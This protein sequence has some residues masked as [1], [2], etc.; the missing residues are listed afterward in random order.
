MQSIVCTPINIKNDYLKLPQKNNVAFS[1]RQFVL[2][3]SDEFIKTKTALSISKRLKNKIKTIRYNTYFSIYNRLKEKLNISDKEPLSI[4]ENTLS[5][6]S[7]KFRKDINNSEAKT[8]CTALPESA[9][10]IM[11]DINSSKLNYDIMH[12]PVIF[13]NQRYEPS[14]YTDNYEDIKTGTNKRADMNEIDTEIMSI[15]DGLILELPTGEMKVKKVK[16]KKLDEP[17]EIQSNISEKYSNSVVWDNNKI[18]RDL[19]QNFFDGHGQ[20]LDGVKIIIEPQKK[21]LN[22]KN[23]KVRIE[24]KSTYNYR[25]AVLLGES[26][27]HDNNKAAGNYGEGLKMVALKLLT[28]SETPEVKIG[29]GNWQVSC[30]LKKDERLDS[31][32]MNYKINPVEEYDGNFVEFE[33]S[34]NG[35]LMAIKSSV[36]RFYHSSNP[37]FKNPDFENDLFGIKLLN[38]CETGGLYISGQQFEYNDKFD[39]FNGIFFVKEKIPADVYN[40]TRDRSSIDEVTLS[41]IAN[42]ISKQTSDDECKQVIKCLDPCDNN[43]SDEMSVIHGEFLDHLA[44]KIKYRYAGAIKFPD[45]YV[46]RVLLCPEDFYCEIEK[47]GYKIYPCDYEELGMQSVANIK[48]KSEQ[49]IPLQPTE[50]EQIKIK[51]LKRA[52]N[53]LSELTKE[54]FDIDELDAKIYIFDRKGKAENS[55]RDYDNTNAEA[56][57]KDN[58]CLGFWID[59]TYLDKAAFGNVLETALHELSHKAGGDNSEDFGYKLTKVNGET[60]KQIFDNPNIAEEL[61]IISDIWSKL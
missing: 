47:N 42:W 44:F 21:G 41:T 56:I 20:T 26:S 23:Y 4:R 22:K 15:K 36:N 46:S 54:H 61:R 51:L 5:A 19:L 16:L 33:T 55:I 43:L 37:H 57:T 60:F 6:Q 49:H 2:V 27:S 25:E 29:S 35:L 38:S 1:G 40:M 32:I 17:F 9:E 8:F 39:N 53:S 48:I 13:E 31:E 45:K 24:G 3:N 59:K 14:E 50:A 30:S 7:E 18:A 28:Q 11:G 58:K 10:N 34:D 12:P 52:L